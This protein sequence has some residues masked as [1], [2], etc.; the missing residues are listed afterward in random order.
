M[1]KLL[2]TPADGK[3]INMIRP[4]AVT[5]CVFQILLGCRLLMT[6]NA[7]AGGLQISRETVIVA[8]PAGAVIDPLVATM[9]STG[10]F[11]VAGKIDARQQAW[12]AEVSESGSV[13]WQ[14][15]TDLEDHL[16]VGQGAEFTGAVAM[17]DGTTFLCGNM[18]RPPG[19][20]APALVV[21][22]DSSGRILSKQFVA[23]HDNANR[24]VVRVQ[25]CIRWGSGVAII[26]RARDITQSTSNLSS[27]KSIVDQ[28][29]WILVLDAS[30]TGKWE[31]RIPTTFDRIDGR[32]SQI[33]M[34]DSSISFSSSRLDATEVF[35][36]GLGG[37]LIAS[38]RITGQY[39]LIQSAT[40]QKLP[41]LFGYAE[42]GTSAFVTLDGNLQKVQRTPEGLSRK[43]FVASGGFTM[44]DKS[45]ILYGSAVHQIGETYTTQI[46]VLYPESGSFQ[47]LGFAKEDYYDL[48]VLSAFTPTKL[49]YEFLVARSLLKR[50][51]RAEGRVG[52]AIDLVT[53][54]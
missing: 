9:S 36:V 30:G 28:Y 23:P 40:P 10:S 33:I 16:P 24:G 26:C 7:E 45:T 43:D 11:I 18:P 19:I 20:Y 3:R 27:Q 29:Y 5:K 37:E 51:A 8:D 53:I 13:V 22:L 31:K 21:R 35:R 15:V 38:T 12:A 32:S 1:A 4:H 46:V 42:D 54:R 52:A 41:Q 47:T 50:V 39:R 14:Y 6:N 2:D 34:A 48:G 25:G 49:D 44:G 17:P